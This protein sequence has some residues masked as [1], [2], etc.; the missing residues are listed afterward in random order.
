MQAFHL[1]LFL[2]FLIT[3]FHLL[4]VLL[5]ALLPLAKGR[6]KRIER[7]AFVATA[8][9][10]IE[11]NKQH[12][13]QH[14]HRNDGQQ[15]EV[16]LAR[17]VEQL[18][19]TGLQQAV[20]SG[21]LLQVEVNIAV[22]VAVHLV[23][24]S[25]I[26]K[27]QLFAN[28]S[29]QV[30]RLI[31][32][33]VLLQGASEA[34]ERRRIVVD[35][36]ITFGQGTVGTRHL[37]NIAITG[38]KVQGPLGEV[39]GQQRVGHI[40]DIDVLHDDRIVGNEPRALLRLL[41]TLTDGLQRLRLP[42]GT[43]KLACRYVAAHEVFELCLN[44][45]L[46]CGFLHNAARSDVIQIAQHLRRVLP[47]E[48]VGVDSDNR[49]NGL[50][51]QS[52]IKKVGG[53]HNAKLYLSVNQAAFLMGRQH[54]DILVK[55]FQP[56]F[57]AFTIVVKILVATFALTKA[58]QLDVGNKL[59]YLVIGLRQHILQLTLG[60]PI[61]HLSQTHEGKV[62]QGLSVAVVVTVGQLH[63]SLRINLCGVEIAIVPCIRLLVQLVD[64]SGVAATTS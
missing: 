49:A 33:A 22:A 42:V 29:H 45:L 53:G 43:L 19:G 8:T 64:K 12:H 41:Q 7:E 13:D 30:G 37:V 56:A 27:A 62:V 54:T 50:V 35:L 2:Q 10:P 3:L 40:V 18:I 38:E 47:N 28:G 46:G 36:P 14:H 60:L 17:G 48:T 34:N 57:G 31:D 44:G 9:H 23:V 20:L 39:S 11:H 15:H 24:N 51:G 58:H 55:A 59:F 25:R 5:I 26:H 52:H 6:K 16:E 61:L 1:H 32:G 21:L 63:G 4:I